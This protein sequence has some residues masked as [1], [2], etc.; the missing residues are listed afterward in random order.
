MH[1]K[2]L[3]VRNELIHLHGC[4][5]YFKVLRAER[6]VTLKLIYIQKFAQTEFNMLKFIETSSEV[7][8]SAR[9]KFDV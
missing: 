4:A 9:I 5:Y 1:V 3:Q 6:L 7:L 2:L 8:G